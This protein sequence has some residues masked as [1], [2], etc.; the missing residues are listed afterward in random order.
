MHCFGFDEV[1]FNP[2]IAE[3]KIASEV[4][5]NPHI[6]E[7]KIAREMHITLVTLYC[8]ENMSRRILLKNKLNSTRM[9]KI[10]IVASY[11]MKTT[12]LRY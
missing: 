1:P 11:L 12:E 6:V 8:S 9:N 5:F 7:K 10:D 2:H 3:K 4:P